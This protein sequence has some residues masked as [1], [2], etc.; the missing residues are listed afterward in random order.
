MTGF[1]TQRDLERERETAIDRRRGT[2]AG[3]RGKKWAVAS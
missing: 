3:E 1:D 2:E